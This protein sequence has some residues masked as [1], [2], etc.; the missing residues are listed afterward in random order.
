MTCIWAHKI[1]H[2]LVQGLLAKRM[3]KSTLIAE[4]WAGMHGVSVSTVGAM[5]DLKVKVFMGEED[6]HRQKMNVEKMK[7]LG[8]EVIPVTTWSRT[9]KDAVN[10]SMKYRLDHTQD[11]YNLIWSAL[12]PHPFPSIV[13]EAQSIVWE[14]TK[15]QFK[16]MTSIDLPNYIIACVGGWSN[17]IGIFA[18]FLEETSVQLIWV[19]AWGRSIQSHGEHAARVEWIGAEI[20]IFHWY[21]SYF[22]Q[23]DDGN[24][25]S[26]HSVSAGLDYPGLGPEHAYL[27]DIQRVQYTSASD[28]EVMHAFQV[29]AHT[30]GILPALESAHAVAY[31]LKLAPALSSEK[32]MIINMS[33]RW[34]KDLHTVI[35]YFEE[36]PEEIIQEK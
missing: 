33:W 22:L 7:L 25:A 30:E 2:A 11:V 12:W 14:E 35:Q 16:N 1:N 6:T 36:H 27:H 20:G 10:A 3:D 21:K 4:T 19:E 28:K 17:A 23:H 18:S 34:D 13:R 32:H 5:L 9:L 24:I 15:Q 8:A 31:A 29:C 26:T